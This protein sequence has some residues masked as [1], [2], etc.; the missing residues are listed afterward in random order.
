MTVPIWGMGC[1]GGTGGVLI[2]GATTGV[3]GAGGGAAG[4]GDG[5]G[6]GAGA[7]GA[8]GGPRISPSID[9][10]MGPTKP[11]NIPAILHFACFPSNRAV[12]M[13]GEG[14][15]LGIEDKCM[16]ARETKR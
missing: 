4:A 1:D 14:D 10:M 3:A 9:R 16:G 8:G 15:F 2:A 5:A 11:P 6:G 13:I 7:R 12:W